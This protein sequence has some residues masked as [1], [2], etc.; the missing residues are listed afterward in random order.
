MTTYYIFNVSKLLLAEQLLPQRTGQGFFD[1]KLH[2]KS[3][4]QTLLP[5]SNTQSEYLTE[6]RPVL[7]L[8][9]DF[10]DEDAEIRAAAEL[11]SEFFS[12]EPNE[13]HAYLATFDS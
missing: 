5:F 10:A 4:R 7:I 6:Y 2:Q 12:V 13:I 9:T 8:E 3:V 11:E 1:F